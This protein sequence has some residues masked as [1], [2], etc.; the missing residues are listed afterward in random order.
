[1]RRREIITLIAGAV[2]QGR[3]FGARAQQPQRMKRVAMVHPA[4][5]PAGLVARADRVIE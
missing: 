1:M 2:L 5:K 4:T 3:T